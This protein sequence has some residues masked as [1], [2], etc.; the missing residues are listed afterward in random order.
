M[1]L[2]YRVHLLVRPNTAKNKYIF[3]KTENAKER[4]FWRHGDLSFLP[5][6][7]ILMP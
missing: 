4:R 5:I 2:N 7:A 3:Y 6:S 1:C